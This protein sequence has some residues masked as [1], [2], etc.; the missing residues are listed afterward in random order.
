MYMNP[1][2]IFR[3]DGRRVDDYDFGFCLPRAIFLPS[4]VLTNWVR[5]SP[6]TDPPCHVC[7]VFIL[8]VACYTDLIGP[9]VTFGAASVKTKKKNKI[10]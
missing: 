3:N 5:V 8:V 10:T 6:D 2:Q 7:H 9:L 4:S 1:A